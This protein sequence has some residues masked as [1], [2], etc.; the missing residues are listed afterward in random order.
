MTTTA[1]A[2]TPSTPAEILAAVRP[3]DLVVLVGPSGAGKS[4]F[5]RELLVAEHEIVSLD[6]LRAVVSE[7]G[8]QAATADALLLQ[9]QVLAMRLRRGATTWI[10]ATS[11]LPHHRLA[12]RDLAAQHARRALAVV[13]HAPL[14]ACLARQSDRGRQARVP[15]HVVR[16][17]HAQALAAHAALPYEGFA[18][19]HHLTRR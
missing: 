7:P 12:L 1:T 5:L 19:I 16:E 4:T 8:D 6:R 3:G 2:S 17:Q 18:E 14:E 13:V 9:H 15:D 11:L 10:D